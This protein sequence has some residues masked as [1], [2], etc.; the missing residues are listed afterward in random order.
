[1][2]SVK[3]LAL[4]SNTPRILTEYQLSLVKKAQ[5]GDEDA[6]IQLFSSFKSLIIRKLCKN[7]Y[8]LPHL[9]N[10]AILA[11]YPGFEKALERF[12]IKRGW[13]FST[14]AFY[15]FKDSFMEWMRMQSSIRLPVKKCQL[16]A[17]L[18]KYLNLA[19]GEKHFPWSISSD[20]IEGFCRDTGHNQEMVEKLVRS[21]RIF[22]IEACVDSSDKQVGP[23][24]R[25]ILYSPEYIQS[26]PVEREV[27]QILKKEAMEEA[28]EK[29]LSPR[30]R[31][32][33]ELRFGLEENNPHTLAETGFKVGITKEW[34]RRI[35]NGA[36]GKIKA[37]LL[38]RYPHLCFAT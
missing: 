31:R 21:R 20:L 22:N 37:F 13:Q 1:M 5:K 28:I 8:I 25:E 29:S 9:W 35:Q 17:K 36:L 2:N 12:E 26:K 34:V 38:K 14:Y 23:L 11:T 30:E 10:D 32:I 4:L 6:K 24:S 18:E 16:L 7:Y 27:L 33:I 3:G 15:Y 19:V